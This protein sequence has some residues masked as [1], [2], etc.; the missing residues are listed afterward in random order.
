MIVR[1][2]GL[3]QARRALAAPARQACLRALSTTTPATPPPEQPPNAQMPQPPAIFGVHAK[4]P[5]RRGKKPAGPDT[6]VEDYHKIRQLRR[7]VDD[8]GSRLQRTYRPVDVFLNPPAPKDVTLELLLASQAHMGHHTSQWNPANAQHIYG[9][10]EGIHIIS[11]EQTAAHLRRAA[12]VVE[13]VAY[14]AGLILFVG[15]RRGQT[16]LVT[17]AAAMAKACHLFSKWTP[18]SITNSEIILAGTEIQIL[19]EHD[20]QIPGFEKHLDERLPLRPDLVVC[21]NPLENYVLLHECSLV[22]IPTIGVIDTNAEPSWV[23]YT[24][25]ANDDSLRCSAVIAAV[26]GRAGQAGHERRLRDAESGKVAWET[27]RDVKMFME[28]PHFESDEDDEA[29]DDQ[30]MVDPALAKK[31]EHELLG[32]MPSGEPESP[33]EP[34]AGV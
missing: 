15:T 13:E 31:R 1:E 22:D 25:P 17:Q 4:Q 12:R 9:V 30:I 33:T 11:L 24:I 7:R 16:R 32:D 14:R 19:D 29:D 34:G 5:S 6:T 18:G 23:T 26:L 8:V 10:R 27:P 2:F 3:R 20:D 28:S 21:L